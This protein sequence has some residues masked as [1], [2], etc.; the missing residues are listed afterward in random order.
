MLTS[1]LFLTFFNSRK[2]NFTNKVFPFCANI[3]M[4]LPLQ[5]AKQMLHSRF[6]NTRGVKRK[7]YYIWLIPGSSH[8]LCEEC[9][10]RLGSKKTKESIVR[11]SKAFSALQEMLNKFDKHPNVSI[12]NG[13]HQP[14]SHQQD[15]EFIIEQLQQS[16]LFDI[17]PNRK[18]KH[19]KNSLHG[20]TIED[21]TPSFK[22]KVPLNSSL[23]EKYL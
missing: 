6:I 15:V 9:V 2:Q 13:A 23:K 22:R 3:T 1:Q 10:K 7:K 19:F 5:Q 18:H 20:K 21:V 14:L 17:I 8:K 4:L 16:K 11:C 12:P